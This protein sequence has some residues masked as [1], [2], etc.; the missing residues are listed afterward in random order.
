[1]SYIAEY[2]LQ[3]PLMKHSLEEVNNMKI[4][5]LDHQTLPD[6]EWQFVFWASDDDFDAFESTLLSD[7]MVSDYTLLS[8]FSDRRLYRVTFSPVGEYTLTY[9]LAAQFDIV[10]LSLEA[11][12]E[13]TTIQAR[14]PDRQALTSYRESCEEIDVNFTLVSLYSEEKNF[15][16]TDGT[17][18]NLTKSQYEALTEALHTGYFD[19]PRQT[20]LEDIAANLG[21]TSQA[22]SYRL[23]RGHKNLVANTLDEDTDI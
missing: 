18:Y 7:P 2:I 1:M 5:G 13:G 11:N 3:P 8:E 17:K 4:E 20:T 10:Y 21:I 15:E 9:P 23:R 22:V 19:V 12:Y 14:V 6:G 16:D